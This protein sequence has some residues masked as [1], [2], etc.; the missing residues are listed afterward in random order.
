[1][2]KV[3]YVY[4]RTGLEGAGKGSSGTFTVE[5]ALKVQRG[6]RGIVLFVIS[7]LDGSGWSTLRLGRFY[8][9]E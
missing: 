1:M 2:V 5:Q 4:C 7:E 3:V 9:R 6:R 8:P